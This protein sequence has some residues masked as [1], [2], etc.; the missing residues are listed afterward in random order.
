MNIFLFLDS[1]L[2]ADVNYAILPSMSLLVIRGSAWRSEPLGDAL[3]SRFWSPFDEV[4]RLRLIVHESVSWDD[5][6]LDQLRSYQGVK[7]VVWMGDVGE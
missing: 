1:N 3:N 7:S 4:T 5:D 6:E 2:Y